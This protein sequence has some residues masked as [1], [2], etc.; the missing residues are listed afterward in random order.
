[1]KLVRSLIGML[2]TIS[3]L[4]TLG[5]GASADS[6]LRVTLDEQAGV[7]EKSVIGSGHRMF[8]DAGIVIETGDGKIE[9]LDPFGENKLGK[10]YDDAK[11]FGDGTSLYVVTDLSRLPNALSLVKADGTVLLED[12]AIIGVLSNPVYYGARFAEVSVAVKETESEDE[13]FLFSYAPSAQIDVRLEPGVEIQCIRVIRASTTCRRSAS[14]KM[15]GSTA[16][17]TGLT[18]W[19]KTC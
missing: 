12:A 16:Q 9:I 18:W 15:S 14:L 4:F 17:A 5:F 6:P 8:E 10:S 13:C 3:F 1:M 11:A 19:A 2:L 7:V